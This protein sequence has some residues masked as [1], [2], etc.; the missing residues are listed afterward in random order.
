ML[1]LGTEVFFAFWIASKRV[2][3]PAGSGPPMRAATSMFLTSLANSLPRLAS[4]TTFL[5]FVVAHLECPAIS[6][7]PTLP[8]SDGGLPP[9]SRARPRG[10]VRCRQ[11]ARGTARRSAAHDARRE[12]ADQPSVGGDVLQ[13]LALTRTGPRRRPNEEH[14][15]PLHP[16]RDSGADQVPHAHPGHGPVACRPCLGP[17]AP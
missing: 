3:L 1:S 2:G 10:E 16:Q 7:L 17:A 6:L 8:P 4:M 14:A 15:V 12:G 13:Q 11:R 9:H 5:C